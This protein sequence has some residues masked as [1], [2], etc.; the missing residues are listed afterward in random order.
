MGYRQQRLTWALFA[1]TQ[2]VIDFSMITGICTL[3]AAL[4]TFGARVKS[5]PW[6]RPTS[7]V[8]GGLCLLGNDTSAIP[9]VCLGFRVSGLG[10]IINLRQLLSVRDSRAVLK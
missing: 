3:G 6:L 8:S 10:L 5:L 1:C 7:N 9:V 2:V 4:D